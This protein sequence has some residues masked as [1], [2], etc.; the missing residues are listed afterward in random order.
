MRIQDDPPI[1]L[2]Y[3]LNV[4]A[5]QT[6]AE[7]LAA[8]REK[9]LR[10]R[11]AV[12]GDR[13]AFG[14]GLRLSAQA[15]AELH[16]ADVLAAFGEF[17]DREN[18]YVFTV[19]AFPYGQF[20]DTAVKEDVYRPDW[21]CLRRLEYTNRV[22]DVLAGLLPEGVAGSISTVPGSY[23]GW[24]RTREDLASMVQMIADA[25]VH[26]G[27]L[28][29]HYGKEICLA[30]E[31]EPDCYLGNM[32]ETLEF[33]AGHLLEI[34]TEHLMASHGLDRPKAEKILRRHVGVC[35]DTAHMAVEFED[36]ADALGRLRSAGVP[37][38]KV[39]LSSALRLA[40]TVKTLRRL[41]EF[42]EEVYLHQVKARGANGQIRSYPDLPAALQDAS[43]AAS[44]EEWRVHFHVPLFFE[45]YQGLRSTRGLFTDEF[46]AALTGGI[47][48]QIEIETYTFGVLPDALRAADI[49]EA[50]ARE[51]DWVLRR[52]LGRK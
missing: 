14:L 51:Y 35:F 5:G 15:S 29:D 38:A 12:A 13:K 43:A 22:A 17:L 1:H 8:I 26:L 44:D 10:V 7:N 23:K 19:N 4:H 31:P 18:L 11:D 30:L 46:V 25:A 3:C 36:L 40:P 27:F 52:M 32:D 41:E 21:R 37:L 2:T 16:H 50:I 34:G 20:H 24:I 28:R 39:H 48:Q 33:C 9:T 42:S 45:G 6:W 49:P 47:T